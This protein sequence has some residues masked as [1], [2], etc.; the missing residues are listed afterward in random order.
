MALP[1]T[2]AIRYTEEDADNFSIRPVKRQTFRLEELVDMVLCVTGKDQARLQQ[3][4]R[5]GTVVYH[6]YRYWWQGFDADSEEL[7]ALLAELPGD[8]PFRIFRAEDCALVLLER[9]ASPRRTIE[10]E[11][12]SVDRKPLFAAQSFWDCLLSRGRTAA[13]DYAGYS[14]ERRADLYHWTLAPEQGRAVLHDAARLAPRSVRTQLEA[15]G[16]PARIT[17]VCPR[18]K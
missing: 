16:E 18:H 12:H 8:D 2:I 17:F 10:I 13:L 3:I 7:S 1:R 5:S 11:R 14:F 15:S 4:L 6:F 9:S